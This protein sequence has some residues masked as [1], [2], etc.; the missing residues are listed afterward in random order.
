[1]SIQRKVSAS[2]TM[3]ITDDEFLN[4]E[5]GYT[6]QFLIIQYRHLLLMT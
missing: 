1:M 4:G 3:N 5:K 2:A 6:E